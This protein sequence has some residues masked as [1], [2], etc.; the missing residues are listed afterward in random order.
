[1]IG[2]IDYGVGNVQ[3]LLDSYRFLEIP[4]KRVASSDELMS[5]NR[6][7]LPGVG[8]FDYALKRLHASG[9]VDGLNSLVLIDKIPILGICVGMQMMAFS[10]AEGKEEG[11]GY[12]PGKVRYLGENLNTTMKVPHVGWNTIEM[13]ESL[14]KLSNNKKN[15]NEFYFLH[16]YHFCPSDKTVAFATTNYGFEFVSIA[17]HNNVIGMQCHPEKSHDAGMNFLS[18]FASF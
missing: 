16:S 8:H 3:A 2:I 13:R 12:L 14:K 4:A 7:I 15:T 10:S 11:L 18:F 1:M 17:T 9:L 6:L 5:C